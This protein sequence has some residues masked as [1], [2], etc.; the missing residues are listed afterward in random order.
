MAKIKFKFLTVWAIAKH[1][2][3]LFLTQCNSYLLTCLSSQL[4]LCWPKDRLWAIWMDLDF[5]IHSLSETV[6][7]GQTCEVDTLMFQVHSPSPF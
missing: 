6:G 4:I 5:M 7:L 3:I 1:K 2:A